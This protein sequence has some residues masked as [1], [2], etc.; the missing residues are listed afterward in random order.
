MYLLEGLE[1][2]LRVYKV[3]CSLLPATAAQHAAYSQNNNICCDSCKV[4]S[5]S[6]VCHYCRCPPGMCCCLVGCPAAR[7]WC[8]HGRPALEMCSARGGR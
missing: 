5:L 6:S 4:L 8:V 3:Q 2:V 1:S 7:W